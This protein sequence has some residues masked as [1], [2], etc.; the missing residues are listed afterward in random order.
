MGRQRHETPCLTKHTNIYWFSRRECP[1]VS[2]PLTVW[3]HR[4]NHPGAGSLVRCTARKSALDRHALSEFSGAFPWT[5]VTISVIKLR[6]TNRR[7]SSA[8]QGG[9]P[10]RDA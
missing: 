7:R 2:V 1:I 8:L 10:Y 6:S 5:C 4:T 3:P 9:H